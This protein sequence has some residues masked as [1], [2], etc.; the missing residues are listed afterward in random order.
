MAKK[1]SATARQQAALQARK[2]AEAQA[3]ADKRR[4]AVL[5]GIG[6]LLLVALFGWLVY[7]IVSSG[8]V[9]ALADVEDQPLGATETGGILVGAEGAPIEDA[10]DAMVVDIYFDFMCPFCGIFEESNSADL[11]ELREAG[12]IAIEYHPLEFLNRFSQGTDYSTRSA[13]AFATVANDAP[14]YTVAFMEALFVNQPAE[15]TEGL[16]DSQMAEIAVGVGVPQEVADTFSDGIYEE[17]VAA[18]TTEASQG[19]GVTG[20]PSV[21]V[22]GEN[23]YGMRTTTAYDDFGTTLEGEGVIGLDYVQTPGALRAYIDWALAG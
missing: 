1:T 17:W 11:T 23:L 12:D 16:S 15:N 13:N 4:T 22:D 20:T 2:A 9:S 5:A 14:E 6:G 18:A 19:A 7:F 8:S 10:G 3:A 21:F